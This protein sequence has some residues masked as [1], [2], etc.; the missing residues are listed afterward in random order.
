MGALGLFGVCAPPQWDGAGADFVAY[1][2]A[3]EEIAYGDAG[4]SN[5]M[6]ATNSPYNAAILAYGTDAQKAHSCAPPRRA[7]SSPPSC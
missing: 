7:A 2:L 3:M 6:A 4:I 1:V 5:M